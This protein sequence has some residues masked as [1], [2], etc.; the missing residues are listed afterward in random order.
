MYSHNFNPPPIEKVCFLPSISFPSVITTISPCCV[1]DRTCD[2]QYLQDL[3][4]QGI[5]MW[6][7][8]EATELSLHQSIQ[9]TSKTHLWNSPNFLFNR[10]QRGFLQE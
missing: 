8:A 1:Q 10:Q 6:F 9:T 3:D 7:S 4:H 5:A 2:K